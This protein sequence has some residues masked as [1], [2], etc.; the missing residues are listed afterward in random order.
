MSIRNLNR[1]FQP[2]SVAVIGASSEADSVGRIVL[3][4]LRDETFP[5]PV[6]PINPKYNEID[7]S[8]CYRSIEDVH[9]P[10]DLAIVC[11]P[12]ATVPGI[13]EACG[14][15]GVSTLII[16]SAGFREIGS[17]G[18]VL[19][20]EVQRCAAKH[21]G[22]RVVGP[23]CLG[24][25][26]PYQGLNAS[27]A[28]RLPKPGRTAFI[29]Q[30]GALCAAIVDW[31]IEQ[32]IGF[33]AV[34]SVGNASD[35]D[36]GD[37]IDYLATDP[38]TDSIVLYVESIRDARKFMSA[39]RA[40]TR[41]K[42][43]VAYK[44]GRFAASAQAAAS[45]T[46]AMVGEDSVYDAAFA[47]AG[48]VRVS[49]MN[50]LFS[51]AEVLARG[52]LPKGSQ[53]AIVSNAGGP[54]IMATDSL[55]SRNGSIASLSKATT[56]K[57]NQN[58]PSA[59][60]HQNPIDILGDAPPSRYGIAVDTALRDN[61]VDG[62]VVLLTPQ[63]MT[64]ATV[65]ADAIIEASSHSTKP[66]LAVW[67]GGASVRNGTKRLNQAGIPTFQ[68]PE[69][70]VAAFESLVQYG[71]RRDVLYE[72]PH[73]R[74]IEFSRK[75]SERDNVFLKKSGM[76]NEIESKAIL[77]AY[78]I[79]TNETLFASDVREAVAI[80]K[81]LGCPVAMK[82]VSPDISHKTNVGGVVL[83]VVGDAEVAAAF[84]KIIWT[85]SNSRPGSRL[86]GVSVQPMV[87]DPN[88]SELIVG[89][90]RD[91]IFGAVLMLGSGGSM[92]E[93]VRDRVV[94]LPPLNDRLARRM[95][96]SMRAW[97][98]LNGYRSR[99]R[100]NID[101]LLDTL[102]RLSYLVAERPE[103]LE[104]DINPLV[105]TPTAVV[106]AD[107]RIVVNPIVSIVTARPYQHLAIRPYPTELTRQ[108]TLDND[109]RVTLRPIRPED[110]QKWIQLIESC[111][112]A[113]I[114]DRFGGLIHTFDHQF[115]ARYC[116]IDYDREMAIVAEI[117]HHGEKKLI[118][119]GRLIANSDRDRASL[120]LLVGD[121]WQR[122]GLGS[123]LADCCLEIAGQW[124]IG[125][126]IA[127]TTADN[128]RAREI[129][130][131]RNFDEA[132]GDDGIVVARRTQLV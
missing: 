23:N 53:L 79:S 29:S 21:R 7:G 121:E 131:E 111:S 101:Q 45:H 25:L 32:G 11:T 67:M 30:S 68:T 12:A 62:L 14:R 130:T 127:E 35:V 100:G 73:E 97:P 119:V 43:I 57:L 122:H 18:L 126:V 24:I 31:A 47:R 120:S 36:L 108:V 94:E 132:V 116:F 44:A 114:H 60:S 105:V 115:A 104:L 72:T 110:E 15:A 39:A 37:M 59:W 112:P 38:Y 51:C 89:V 102:I 70:A 48:I 103:I 88:S 3:S 66:V 77:S 98:I 41:T 1:L 109:Q 19:E 113:T 96:E 124:K 107:A 49:D 78:D 17:S 80:A 84:D 54:G 26:S 87:L 129:L 33:S 4:N 42:P 63:A 99:T 27:F 46:G 82:I 90:K 118:G 69:Q 56:E 123:R 50:E 61:G 75:N 83:N 106:A 64:D 74:S 76:L 6:Y 128:F 71:R 91:P 9:D 95:V 55:L 65:S 117:E 10:I 93:L 92:A 52:K 2:R 58:L 28:R 16:L 34:A 85:V 22:M 5:G 81:R 86:E 20:E 40:F 13:V 125:Q 8:P